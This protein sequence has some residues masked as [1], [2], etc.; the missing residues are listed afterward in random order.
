VSVFGISF[1]DA[2]ALAPYTGMQVQYSS[3]AVN[4]GKCVP[5]SNAVEGVAS[6]FSVAIRLE[7]WQR[8][9]ML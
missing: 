9:H 1:S 3:P 6:M 2:A 4:A 5:I 7:W 8:D